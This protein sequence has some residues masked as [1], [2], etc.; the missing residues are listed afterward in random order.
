M[1]PV[2][3]C[4]SMLV[5]ELL[6]DR[7]RFEVRSGDKLLGTV[8]LLLSGGKLKI[9]MDFDSTVELRKVRQDDPGDREHENR[10]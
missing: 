6:I 8:R 3:G 4:G 1:G 2:G 5:S 7:E 9:G 10:R